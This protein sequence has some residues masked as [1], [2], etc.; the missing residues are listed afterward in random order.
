MSWVKDRLSA[1]E[2]TRRLCRNR[3][4]MPVVNIAARESLEKSRDA[5]LALRL[6]ESGPEHSM[7]I[8]V[9]GGTPSQSGKTLCETCK[10]STITRGRRLE[11]EI[12]RCEAQAVGT[13]FVT[14]IVTECTAYLDAALP[15]YPELFE[16]AW[17]L[18]PRD[19][20]REAGFVRS[21]ELPSKE[22]WELMHEER[23]FD[24]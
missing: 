10:H 21:S 19:G 1:I 24:E 11:D 16:K 7:R 22:R 4:L 9:Y 14:F 5:R 17:I 3:A 18:R 8:R 2:G 13:T 15:S 23:N 6:L 12:I 20:K